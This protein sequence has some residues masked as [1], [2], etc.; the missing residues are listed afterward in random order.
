[1]TCVSAINDLDDKYVFG[2]HHR[3]L[4][5]KVAF[6]YMDPCKANSHFP[7]ASIGAEQSQ[8]QQSQVPSLT[9]A[10]PTALQCF[11]A[12]IASF[13]QPFVAA[14]F[15]CFTSHCTTQSPW[16]RAGILKE[17]PWILYIYCANIRPLDLSRYF[18]ISSVPG[19][20]FFFPLRNAIKLNYFILSQY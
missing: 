19:L 20:F 4:V 1:M 7:V 15:H 18:G 8:H 17:A 5:R 11:A 12:F 3:P 10:D 16:H 13:L 2:G 6:P 14:G 9:G